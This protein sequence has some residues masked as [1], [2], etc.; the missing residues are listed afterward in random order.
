MDVGAKGG[1]GE[2]E[3]AGQM[4]EGVVIALIM[5]GLGAVGSMVNG[6]F[7]YQANRAKKLGNN[8]HPCKAHQ[9]MLEKLDEKLDKACERISRIEGK[10]NGG[11]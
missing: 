5:A 6:Y 10:L 8:P 2:T 7:I 11:R 3:E 1:G 4:T 9:Q